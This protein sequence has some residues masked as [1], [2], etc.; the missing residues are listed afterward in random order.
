[1]TCSPPPTRM[2]GVRSIR[3]SPSNL[4][5]ADEIGVDPVFDRCDL[6]TVRH[7]TI[8]ERVTPAIG[9]ERREGIG[10]L[11]GGCCEPVGGRER[12]PF[13]V[14]D[15]SGHGAVPAVDEQT[16][17]T[18]PQ[19]AADLGVARESTEG[20][21]PP[22]PNQGVGHD[23]SHIQILFPIRGTVPNAGA[24]DG[25]VAARDSPTR[26]PCDVGNQARCARS[27]PA[28]RGSVDRRALRLR[29]CCVRVKVGSGCS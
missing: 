8:G 14:A 19:R 1:M 25:C 9:N 23:R 7:S 18:L 3:R 22:C 15:Q 20:D 29:A 6:D 17:W 24:T 11:M 13:V 16:A 10:L 21:Q 2:G 4:T 28:P 26:P 12:F 27:V 5:R